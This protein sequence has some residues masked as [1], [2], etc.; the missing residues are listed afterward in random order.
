MRHDPTRAIAPAVVTAVPG[1]DF[2]SSLM[3][4]WMKNPP[5]WARVPDAARDEY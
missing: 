4:M 2:P 1:E 3:S 5:D